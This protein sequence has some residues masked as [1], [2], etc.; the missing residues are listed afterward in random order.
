MTGPAGSVGRGARFPLDN[1]G[2]GTART[3]PNGGDYREFR[4]AR[5]PRPASMST[6]LRAA[7]PGRRE[8]NPAHE[9]FWSSDSPASAAAKRAYWEAHGIGGLFLWQMAGDDPTFPILEAMGP[10]A[11]RRRRSH[12]P[13]LR[14]QPCGNLHDQRRS[15]HGRSGRD[16]GRGELERPN[17]HRKP[18]NDQ[19]ERAV[20]RRRRLRARRLRNQHHLHHEHGRGNQRHLRPDQ[21]AER[22]AL[23]RPLRGHD[24]RGP[25][26]L[27]VGRPCR[28][29]ARRGRHHHLQRG[30]GQRR[31][32]AC[33]GRQ[34]TG[35]SASPSAGSLTTTVPDCTVLA[36][37]AASGSHNLAQLAAA[38]PAGWNLVGAGSWRSGTGNQ[39][40]N[41]AF[42]TLGIAYKRCRAAGSSGAATWTA[43]L[44]ASRE[45]FGKQIAI[46][47]LEMQWMP[48]S[49]A[50]RTAM[51][52]QETGEVFLAALRIDHPTSRPRSA[53]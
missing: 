32:A 46:E 2:G 15:Q 47:P 31:A 30:R 9:L 5:T 6:L 42:V 19:P 41:S 35:T 11:D 24:Q 49:T 48:I 29:C 36:I 33:P 43:G 14:G 12:H 16:Q 38:V 52:A 45:W 1:W 26:R 3:A 22:H 39:A 13:Q 4:P 51:F 21:P 50:A 34:P 7:S 40:S 28:F 18:A 37:I 8:R 20:V 23:A 25:G 44:G 53:S 10:P 17:E 27:V